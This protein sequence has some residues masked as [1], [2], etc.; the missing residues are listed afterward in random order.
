MIPGIKCQITVFLT[1]TSMRKSVGS[2]L[3]GAG[4]VARLELAY[5]TGNPL[6]V[7]VGRTSMG[8]FYGVLQ[9][10]ILTKVKI[11]ILQDTDI[12][13]DGGSSHARLWARSGACRQASERLNSD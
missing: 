11:F 10:T 3:D 5:G 9:N 1:L 8:L 4:T 13:T 12:K 2:N 6:R 7:W